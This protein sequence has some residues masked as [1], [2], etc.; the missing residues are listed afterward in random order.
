[1]AIP[2]QEYVVWFNVSVYNA[3]IVQE[4]NCQKNLWRVESCQVLMESAKPELEG[5]KSASFVLF[6]HV[7]EGFFGLEIWEHLNE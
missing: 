3:A 7:T 6:H 2:V 4:V 5:M 1:M